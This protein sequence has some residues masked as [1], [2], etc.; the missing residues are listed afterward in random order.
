LPIL[1]AHSSKKKNHII[2]KMFFVSSLIVLF[3]M[4]L[5][6]Q[7][8]KQA[9]VAA[10]LE[11]FR[12]AIVDGDSAKLASLTD[13]NLTYGHSL[14][15]LENKQQFVH[16]LASGESDFKTLTISDQT[17]TVKNKIAVVR[18][19]I[20]A[21]IMENGKVNNVKLAVL[22]IFNK[23]KKHWKLIARQAIRLPN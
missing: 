9:Q 1:V 12:Q 16:A 17:I 2:M 22:L 14:G 18:H 19:K 20:N 8:K 3:G 15:K 7:D 23:E 6:A 11:E 4:S 10:T 21:D 5:Q 13:D